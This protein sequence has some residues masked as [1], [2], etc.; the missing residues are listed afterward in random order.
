MGPH[1]GKWFNVKWLGINM[2]GR[3]STTVVVV[4]WCVAHRSQSVPFDL[5]GFAEWHGRFCSKG[6]E[7]LLAVI[8]TDGASPSIVFLIKAARMANSS[9][10]TPHPRMAPSETAF[11]GL[12]PPFFVF[13]AKKLGKNL[14][15][16]TKSPTFAP[17]KEI[18][19]RPYV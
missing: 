7:R 8:I 11:W 1:E 3:A 6:K 12:N 5:W 19:H 2:S 9:F 16:P 18:R 15:E 17:A 4:D 13:G 14:E 10:R